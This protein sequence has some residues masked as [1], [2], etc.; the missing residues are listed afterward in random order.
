MKKRAVSEIVAT[1]LIIVIVVAA[2]GI[3]W[4]TVY[5]MIKNNMDQG[6]ACFN[7]QKS[8]LILENQYTCVNS[9]VG[10]TGTVKVNVQQNPIDGGVNIS[11]YK[12]MVIKAGNS[13]AYDEVAFNGL[14]KVI[15]LPGDANRNISGATSVQVLPV[16]KIGRSNKTCEAVGEV[17]LINCA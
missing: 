14:T 10:T 5:P 8:V 13:N 11:G 12:I 6:T 4:A 9:T 17:A 16:V 2:V 1:V 15:T 7:A 3:L